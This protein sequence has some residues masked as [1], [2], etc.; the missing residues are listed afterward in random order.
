MYLQIIWMD[1]ALLRQ[2]G[3]RNEKEMLLSLMISLHT[4][5]YAKINQTNNIFV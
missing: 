1:S 4:V 3:G 5:Y 2:S